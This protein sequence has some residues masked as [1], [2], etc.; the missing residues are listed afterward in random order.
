MRILCLLAL[1]L[2]CS[3]CMQETVRFQAKPQQQSFVRDGLPALVSQKKDSIVIIRPASRQFQ[4]GGRPVFVV[5]IRNLTKTPFDFLVGNVQVTQVTA[6]NTIA[7][8]VFSYEELVQEERNRQV[9]MAILVGAAEGLNAYSAANA[10]YSNNTTTRY[11]TTGA[12][13]TYSTSYSSS[14]A[15]AAQSRAFRENEKMTDAAIAQGQANLS[16][17]ERDVIKDNTLMPGEWYG[18]TLHVAPPQQSDGG[19]S[20]TYSIAVLV[21]SDR[22]EIDIQQDT[23]H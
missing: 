5:G 23:A 17:L 19:A 7:L 10:G 1:A 12:H 2:V 11:T 4:A 18:G 15:I 21:G 3:A 14:R 9:A 22:H 13:T 8:K 20:K 6:Q 16:N